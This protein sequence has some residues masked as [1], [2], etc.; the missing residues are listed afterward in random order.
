MEGG[1]AQ[2]VNQGNKQKV[3]VENIFYSNF[4]LWQFP[5]VGRNPVTSCLLTFFPPQ[6]QRLSLH[7][8]KCTHCF[9]L[10]GD[11]PKESI[12][13]VQIIFVKQH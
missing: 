1:A 11:D 3:C 12:D 9:L 4:R 10:F 6:K 13:S 8:I 5:F 2:R 7:L